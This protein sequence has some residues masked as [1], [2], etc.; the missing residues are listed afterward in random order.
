MRGARGRQLAIWINVYE[1]HGVLV[2]ARAVVLGHLLVDHQIVLQSLLP[3]D[4]I[5]LHHRVGVHL[6]EAGPVEHVGIRL[7]RR[8][9]LAH[10][11]AFADV[12]HRVASAEADFDRRV[13]IN[14]SIVIVACR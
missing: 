13:S 14:L 12:G 4:V 11:L 6:V 10:H 8:V 3:V 5:L 1:A 2:H 9:L 7:I